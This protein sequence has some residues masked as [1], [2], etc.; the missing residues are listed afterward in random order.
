MYN[1]DYDD[2]YFNE[3]EINELINNKEIDYIIDIGYDKDVFDYRYAIEY[4]SDFSNIIS[5]EGYTIYRII[6]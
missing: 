5:D 3:K 6:E 1:N 4:K 2:Y